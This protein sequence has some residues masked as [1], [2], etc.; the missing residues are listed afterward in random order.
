VAKSSRKSIPIILLLFLFIAAVVILFGFFDITSGKQD[1]VYAKV[2]ISQ[3]LWWS[4]T[5]RPNY[6]FIENLK[7]GDKEVG[8]ANRPVAELID[9][10]YYPYIS[11]AADTLLNS[12]TSYNVYLHLKLAVKKTSKAITFKREKIA[13]GSPIELEFPA[14]HITGTVME[15]ANGPIKDEYVEKTIYLTGKNAFYWEYD[16][17][18][19]GDSYFDGHRE[20]FKVLSKQAI[21]TKVIDTDIYGNSTINDIERRKYVTVKALV[22]LKKVKGDKLFFGEEQEMQV[23]TPFNLVTANHNYSFLTISKIE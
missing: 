2:K 4:N 9:F 12:E 21:D 17:I 5:K 15:L 11:A 18:K 13:V 19:I 7:A 10:T 16:S 23:G 3:G 1:Y 14:V 6:W 8:T 22:T 20:V